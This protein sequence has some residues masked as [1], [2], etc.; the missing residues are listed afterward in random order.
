MDSKALEAAAAVLYAG[1][2]GH[3]AEGFASE[4]EGLKNAYLVYARAAIEAN[5]KAEALVRLLEDDETVTI[6]TTLRA[7]VAELEVG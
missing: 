7:R 5:E 4:Y 3:K 1:R 6:I 2:T